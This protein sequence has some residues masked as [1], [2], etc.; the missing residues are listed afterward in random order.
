MG[1]RVSQ[2]SEIHR[3]S[4]WLIPLG[5]LAVVAALCGAFL[6]YYLR[7]A[8]A[9]FRDNRP[10]AATTMVHLSVRGLKLNVPARY[11]ESRAAR[12]GG[13]QDVVPLFAALPDMRGFSDAE[14]AL[15]A[16]NAADSPTVH[17]VIRADTN[18]LD[19][20]SRLARIYMPY[21]LDPKGEPAP[22][23]LVRYTFRP[24]SGYGRDDLYVGN[25][26]DMLFR[27]ERPAQNLPSPNCLAIERPIAQGVNLSYRFK[28]AQL[29]RW[30]GIN[31]GI[32]RLVASFRE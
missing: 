18:G 7:P 13:D 15:F 14:S 11:I 22:F 25:D 19:T 24:D 8:T 29:S 4:G 27:C 9:P 10:T 32:G 2:D 20:R 23:D 28:R 6:L 3:H 31:G 16:S 12:G 21:I 30:Q 1:G 26:G 5:F 17:I